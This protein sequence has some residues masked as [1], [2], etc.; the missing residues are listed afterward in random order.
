[1]LLVVVI[2]SVAV[3]SHSSKKEQVVR[4]KVPSLRLTGV[5]V[6]LLTDHILA[7]WDTLFHGR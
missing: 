7:T 5:R 6:V 4:D 2:C 1:M 3:A